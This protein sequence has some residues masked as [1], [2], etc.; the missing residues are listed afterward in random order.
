MRFNCTTPA[1]EFWGLPVSKKRQAAVSFHLKKVWIY[2]GLNSLCSKHFCGRF[3]FTCQC[4]PLCCRVWCICLLMKKMVKSVGLEPVLTFWFWILASLIEKI[5]L[6]WPWALC[7]KQPFTCEHFNNSI[8]LKMWCYREHQKPCKL[9]FSIEN[10]PGVNEQ[11][12]DS[13]ETAWYK[14]KKQLHN[15]YYWKLSLCSYF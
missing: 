8:K 10:Q 11:D 12:K 6:N 1:V 15:W 9:P 14:E 7:L 4:A 5:L 13:G 2:L 3:Q